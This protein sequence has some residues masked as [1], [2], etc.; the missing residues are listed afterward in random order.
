MTNAQTAQSQTPQK[1]WQAIESVNSTLAETIA[2]A[3]DDFLDMCTLLKKCK[4]KSED[5][6]TEISAAVRELQHI[7]FLRQK[8]GHVYDL[9]FELQKS[10]ATV[11][12]DEENRYEGHGLIFRVNYFQLMAA[13]EDY[14]KVVLSVQ[15]TIRKIKEHNVLLINFNTSIFPNRFQIDDNF[16]TL[17]ISLGS[18]ADKNFYASDV[19]LYGLVNRISSRYTMES[20]RV[21]L[22]WCIDNSESSSE[23]NFMDHYKASSLTDSIELF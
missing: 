16:R 2:L 23:D 10:R 17:G 9:H 11:G 8:L 3:S 14:I 4:V 5:L 21:V 1:Y 22:Q 15:S 19:E 18:L 13:H 12:I 6:A 20:E 7:D